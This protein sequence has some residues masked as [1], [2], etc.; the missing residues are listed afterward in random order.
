MGDQLLLRFA[1]NTLI[2]NGR[3]PRLFALLD[4]HMILVGKSDGEKQHH[5]DRAHLHAV[6]GQRVGTQKPHAPQQKSTTPSTKTLHA[7]RKKRA[8]R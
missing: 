8:G 2:G 5:S 6:Q 7:A 3:L 1:G 4:Q